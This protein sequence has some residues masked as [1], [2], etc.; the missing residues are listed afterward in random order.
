MEN[1][2]LT[3]CMVV[4]CRRN[5]RGKT[6]SPVQE[7]SACRLFVRFVICICFFAFFILLL[8]YCFTSPM[9]HSINA[10]FDNN[11]GRPARD[12]PNAATGVVVVE[13][14]AA[15]GR[16]TEQSNGTFS[17]WARDRLRGHEF[18]ERDGRGASSWGWRSLESAT[19]R[20]VPK[21]PT[22]RSSRATKFVHIMH[23]IMCTY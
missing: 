11:A 8:I 18:D 20:M 1:T 7:H 6:A 21:V 12:N 23:H 2:E 3:I 5:F 13:G 22:L 17:G 4:Q 16:S 15:M 14:C 10:T 19:C 9:P